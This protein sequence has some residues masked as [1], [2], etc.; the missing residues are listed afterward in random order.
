MSLAADTM[1][2]QMWHKRLS[3]NAVENTGFSFF[4]EITRSFLLVFFLFYTLDNETY[5][6][7]CI[8]I[9]IYIVCFAKLK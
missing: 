1:S 5:V 3:R 2:L 8:Y 9:Y 4:L 6:C 7:A